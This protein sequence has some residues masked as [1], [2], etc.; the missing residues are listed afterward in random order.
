MNLRGFCYAY[1]FFHA[2]VNTLGCNYCAEIVFPFI[3]IRKYHILPRFIA[4][5]TLK[6]LVISNIVNTGDTKYH[7]TMILTLFHASITYLYRC[8]HGENNSVF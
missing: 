6:L 8:F 5:A 4:T 2:W 7:F 1:I 3:C